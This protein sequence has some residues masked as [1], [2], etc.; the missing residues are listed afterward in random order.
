MRM[1]RKHSDR[2]TVDMHASSVP[3]ELPCQTLPAGSQPALSLCASLPPPHQNVCSPKLSSN[4]RSSSPVQPDTTSSTS[5]SSTTAVR[6]AAG[7]PHVSV[8]SSTTRPMEDR[9]TRQGLGE[10]TSCELQGANLGAA[11]YALKTS[12]QS[13]IDPTERKALAAVPVEGHIF[14]KTHQSVSLMRYGVPLGQHAACT[15]QPGT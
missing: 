9:R 2:K 13:S 14:L 10:A 7:S 8:R 12:V 6:K 3:A 5:L 4:F 11:C 15:M 1:A